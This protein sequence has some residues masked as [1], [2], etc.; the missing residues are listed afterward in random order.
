LEWRQLERLDVVWLHLVRLDL[1][2]CDLVRL[3]LVRRDLVRLDLVRLHLVRLH[4][5]WCDLVWCDLVWLDLVWLDLVRRDLVLSPSGLTTNEE[6]AVKRATTPPQSTAGRVWWLVAALGV[7]A[8]VMLRFLPTPHPDGVWSLLPVAALALAFYMADAYPLHI[9]GRGETFTLSVSEL[10]FV[11]GLLFCPPELIVVARCLGGA[12]ALVLKR[13]QPLHKLV[14]NVALQAFDSSLGVTVYL[15]M[16]GAGS[17]TLLGNGSA[18]AVGVFASSLVA[19]LAVTAAIRI[20]TGRWDVGVVRN[21]ARMALLNLVPDLCAG[22]ILAE[23]IWGSHLILVPALVVVMALAV[24]YR[25]YVDLRHRHDNLRMVYDFVRSVDGSA[26]SES[27]IRHLLE[28]T[29]DVLRS[30]HAEIVL[31]AEDGSGQVT[32]RWVGADDWLQTDTTALPTE[33][34][35]ITMVASTAKPFIAARGT[36]DPAIVGFL[37]WR[38]W[39]DCIVVPLLGEGRTIGVLVVAERISDVMTFTDEDTRLLTTVAAQVASVVE[40]GQLVDRL[41]HD[42]SHDSLTGLANR[43]TYQARLR[44]ALAHSNGAPLAVLLM[45]LDRFKDVN[46]TLGH[47]HGDL[48][49]REVAGR[50]HSAAPSTATV[51]RLGGDEFA[52]LLPGTDHEAAGEAAQRMWDAV[53]RPCCLDGVDLDVEASIGIAVAPEHGDDGT[54][55][56]KRSDMAM[57]AAKRGRTRIEFYDA[58]RDEY[59]PRRL[60]LASQVRAAI[61]N[62]QMELHYQPQI[63]LSSGRIVAVEALCRWRHPDYGLVPPDEFIGL[64]EQSGAIA[65]LTHWVLETAVAQLV[66]WRNAGHQIDVAVNISMRNLIDNSMGNHVEQLMR[67]YHLEPGDLILEVTESQV[68]ADPER[69]LPILNRLAEI[70]ARLSIDDFGTG[71][72]SLAYLKQLPV[73]EVKVDRSFVAGLAVD[74]QDV[75]IV[76]AIVDLAGSLGMRVVAEGVENQPTMQRLAALGCDRVQGFLFSRPLPVD[77]LLT[78]MDDHK[79]EC[80]DQ[81]RVANERHLTAIPMARS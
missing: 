63:D 80:H 40:N 10:P 22:L 79:A 9:E 33:A 37:G 19:M 71:Y 58:D 5:V 81:A 43:T 46:D 29:R 24:A 62:G 30:G 50:L 45:D 65:T 4:L 51:A 38:D 39:R 72:S 55:L 61:E 31:L 28:R 74:H 14:F 60:A 18:A 23:A 44:A 67:A 17:D 59:S 26:T 21:F 68:M 32:R 54:A 69:T 12:G 34:W 25:S 3:V 64:A 8:L 77:E 1:V 76:R 48:L 35:P 15:A 70:G 20:H 75:A 52:I 47:H 27:R 49:I 57:Y 41:T 56:L 36:K 11:L 73:S 6:L 66:Q 13:R 78:W 42:S 7:L 2:R 53:A 16:P